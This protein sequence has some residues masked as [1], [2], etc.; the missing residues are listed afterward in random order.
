L[1]IA[2]STLRATSTVCVTLILAFVIT[3][4]AASAY[5]RERTLLGVQHFE[6]AQALVRRGDATAALEEYRKA[7]IFSP[8]KQDY[9]ISLATALINTHHLD[10]AESHLEQLVQSDPTN[11][12]I[13]LLLARVAVQQRD[14][15]TAINYYQ[16]AVYEYWPVADVP[17]R[18]EARWELANLLNRTGNRTGF[19]AELMQL[20][21]NLPNNDI[22]QKL[23]VGFL[24]AANGATSE[25]SQIFREVNKQNPRNADALRGLGEVSLS[26]GDFVSARRQFQRALRL[27]PNDHESSQFVTLTNNVI[28]IDANLPN[29]SGEERLRR[30]RKLLGDVID[31]IESCY[32]T[33]DLL[34]LPTKA[35]AAKTS[36]AAPASP[37]TPTPPTDPLREQLVV[38]KTALGRDTGSPE[39][40][41][42]KFQTDAQQ[43]WKARGSYCKY[44]EPSDKAIDMVIARMSV[45]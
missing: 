39:D 34:P 12:E 24:L 21:T 6:A 27:D 7:L 8:D 43:L 2:Q 10:E 17:K 35:P 1:F 16:R 40:L 31:K 37:S 45:E 23:R 18:R 29:L 11:G 30:S 36:K 42:T 33:V 15:K 4:F 20:Y 28:D 14:V 44:P 25:A 22:G 38:A 13:N 26:F 9:Q 32:G 41:T 5:R 3:G 19:V